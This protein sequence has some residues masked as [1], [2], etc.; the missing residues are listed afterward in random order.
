LPQLVTDLLG[1]LTPNGELPAGT[2]ISPTLRRQMTTAAN[3]LAGIMTEKDP[4]RETKTIG[5][6]LSSFPRQASSLESMELLMAAFDMA[7]EEVPT[8]AV[9]EAARGWI[10][11]VHGP[12][13]FAPT[14][15]QLRLAADREVKILRGKII[16]LRQLAEVKVEPTPTEEQRQRVQSLIKGLRWNKVEDPSPAAA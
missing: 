13:S 5:L 7:L 12:K 11:G 15:P 1:L 6:L 16:T 2:D 10:A 14:P 8:W 4:K 3:S 9:E